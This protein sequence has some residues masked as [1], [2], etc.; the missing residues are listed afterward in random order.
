MNILNFLKKIFFSGGLRFRWAIFAILFFILTAIALFAVT[1][2]GRSALQKFLVE[3]VISSDEAGQNIDGR[4]IRQKNSSAVV[5][6]LF[7][8]RSV[9]T[10]HIPSV[11]KGEADFFSA[12]TSNASTTINKGMIV[13]G[14]IRGENIDLATGTIFAS[15]IIYDVLSGDGITVS[16]GQRPVFSQTFF[17][18]QGS[19]LAVRDPSLLLLSQG[20]L[21]LGASATNSLLSFAGPAEI[22]FGS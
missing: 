5:P 10:V 16:G 14:L 9:F 22:A 13:K 8:S 17:T 18:I 1:A 4:A 20:G 12:L 11:F 3:S 21:E 19:I 6:V 7:S 15:N 2:R